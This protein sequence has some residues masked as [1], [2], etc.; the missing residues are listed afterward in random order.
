MLWPSPGRDRI[1]P[2]YRPPEARPRQPAL[3][4]AAQPRPRSREQVRQEAFQNTPRPASFQRPAHRNSQPH[5]RASVADGGHMQGHHGPLRKPDQSQTVPAETG[6]RQLGLKELLEDRRGLPHS[7]KH[8]LFRAHLK[9]EPLTAEWSHV[10]G[11]WCVRGDELDM[12]QMRRPDRRQSDQV[13][14]ISTKSVQKHHKRRWALSARSC[15]ARPVK[16]GHIKLQYSIAGG[17]FRSLICYATLTLYLYYEWLLAKFRRYTLSVPVNSPALSGTVTRFAP[18]P[19]GDLHLGHAYSALLAAD[20]AAQGKGT[21]LVRIEDIDITRCRAEHESANLQD[22][23]WLGLSWPEPVRRQSAHFCFYQTALDRLQDM[24]LLYRCFLSRREL[25]EALSAP[26]GA[27]TEAPMDTDQL[28]TEAERQ[29]RLDSGAP[30]SLRLRMARALERTGPLVWTDRHGGTQ[31]SRPEMF[32]DVVLARRDIPTSYHL[33]VTLDDALQGVTLVTRG[34]DLLHATHIHR[35]PS[36]AR[37]SH[38]G[39]SAS[40]IAAGRRRQTPCQARSV[41]HHSSSTRFGI[42]PGG[43]MR[44][45]LE[46][47]LEL[48]PILTLRRASSPCVVGEFSSSVGCLALERLLMS[49][50]AVSTLYRFSA[51][52]ITEPKTTSTATATRNVRTSRRKTIRL[53]IMLK[54]GEAAMIGTTVT[55]FP[56]SNA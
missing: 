54:T 23:R 32:G 12:R 26:H 19:T 4:H 51:I 16:F 52:R 47:R 14:A 3:P 24:G 34:E 30:F 31:Q 6:T 7:L 37:P 55:T 18:S 44:N 25:S 41:D 15:H 48:A 17:W 45:G 38:S 20:L 42:W 46:A 49:S 11:V 5:R 8:Y 39:L 33:A 36:P 35:L 53:S 43:G 50:D 40:W 21:F 2:R 13:V 56:I 29:R 1:R 9:A 28:L 22:L 27:P 10:A